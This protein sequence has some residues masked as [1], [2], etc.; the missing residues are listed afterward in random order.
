MKL[1]LPLGLLAAVIL[2]FGAVVP[3]AQAVNVTVRNFYTTDDWVLSEDPELAAKN[4]YNLYLGEGKELTGNRWAI[5]LYGK[6]Q[7]G[8]NMFTTGKD[9]GDPE[10][11]FSADIEK[12]EYFKAIFMTSYYRISSYN[13]SNQAWEKPTWGRLTNGYLRLNSTVAGMSLAKYDRRLE[14]WVTWLNV[15]TP[16]FPQNLFVDWLSI[17]YSNP[18]YSEF[19]DIAIDVVKTMNEVNVLTW[20]GN[21]NTVM[22]KSN[23]DMYRSFNVAGANDEYS[24]MLR[25][26]G[27]SPIFYAASPEAGISEGAYGKLRFIS[28]GTHYTAALTDAS[29]ENEEAY[30]RELEVGAGVDLRTDPSRGSDFY[31]GGIIVEKDAK[32]Y[33]LS[34]GYVAQGGDTPTLVLGTN[35]LGDTEVRFNIHESFSLGT[36]KNPWGLIRLNTPTN[37]LYIGID[38]GK[39]FTIYGEAPDAGNGRAVIDGGGT[40]ALR[41]SAFNLAQHTTLRGGTTLDFGDSLWENPI[42]IEGGSLVRAE[43]VTGHVLINADEEFASII[44]MGGLA[45]ELVQGIFTTNS[46]TSLRNIGI[47][48]L[49]FVGKD[50]NEYGE[51]EAA[52]TFHVG[53][54]H[55]TEG[56]TGGTYLLH[57][58]NPEESKISFRDGD[59]DA[60]I[61]ITLDD[62]VTEALSMEEDGYE[63]RRYLWFSNAA[64][65]AADV[66]FT[67]Y[68]SLQEWFNK[69]FVFDPGVDFTFEVVEG[70]EAG[71]GRFQMILS[72]SHIWYTSRHGEEINLVD[73]LNDPTHW[74]KVVVDSH[75]DVTLSPTS[76]SN[77]TLILRYLSSNGLD[78]SDGGE[79]VITRDDPEGT[80]YGLTIELNNARHTL[81]GEVNPDSTFKKNI[82]V[83]DNSGMTTLHKTGEGVL[84]IDGNVTS[85]GTVRVDEVGSLELNG[86]D[87]T[88]GRLAGINGTLR[89]GGKLTVTGVSDIR[90]AL[91]NDASVGRIV[92]DGTLIVKGSL[93]AGSRFST[94]NSILLQVD[95]GGIVHLD[96]DTGSYFGALAGEGTIDLNGE[97]VGTTIT[98]SGKS[99][100]FSG[101]LES[102]G[103][104]T[105]LVLHEDTTQVLRTA[106]V[107]SWNVEAKDGATLVLIGTGDVNKRS[108]SITFDAVNIGG[109]DTFDDTKPS[110]LCISAQ[111]HGTEYAAATTVRVNSATF[112]EDSIIEL[113]YNFAGADGEDLNN[114]GPMLEASGNIY[115]DRFVTFVLSNLG[116]SFDL[117]E[118]ADLKDLVVMRTTDGRIDG[119][120]NDGDELLWD[121]SGIFMIFYR[122]IDM[123][124]RGKD[125][126]LNA[127]VQHENVF[128]PYSTDYSAVIGG[129]LLWE[130]RFADSMSDMD[131]TLYKVIDYTAYEAIKGDSHAA[132]RVLAA[133]AGSTVPT[134]GTAQRDAIRSHMIRMRDHVGTMGLNSDFSYDELPFY[135]CWVEGTGSFTKF[136][137]DNL[138]SGYRLNSWGGS[139]GADVDVDNTTSVGIALSALY[140]D[141]S[142]G[143]ADRATGDMDSVYLSLLGRFRKNRWTHTLI[144][145]FGLSDFSVDRTVNYGVGQYETHGETSGWGLAL[146]YE[147]TR[148]YALTPEGDSILQ[149]LLNVSIA[150]TSLRAYNESGEDDMA[151]NVG[152]Q[153]WFSGSV[154]VGV[155]WLGEVGTA[156]FDRAAQLEL[157]A[158][159]AQDFGDT[160]GEAE[161][162]LRANPGVSRKMKANE[163][164]TTALQLGVGLRIPVNEQATIYTNANT[165]FRSGMS[166]WNVTA[167]FRYDF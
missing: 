149:P 44:N 72:A 74:R 101:N 31:L 68:H 89:I 57:F 59:V 22:G 133:V 127:R 75:L 21:G 32:N 153:E 51:T 91:E 138:M 36:A 87:S 103:Q 34:S 37:G 54:Q 155:R 11:E 109:T 160:C 161:V 159:V 25:A 90:S 123:R 92:G 5:Y 88:I 12:G 29:E 3:R 66:D 116:G 131:S 16:A 140:G 39:T 9:N 146:M 55:L 38:E 145:S 154:A 42:L 158:N 49:S 63:G 130:A 129:Q 61:T 14:E 147:I 150:K 4:V 52:S 132:S 121:T 104:G 105:I 45:A 71:N 7:G 86:D 18:K 122:D 167:G 142:A 112:G 107:D 64:I 10:G 17:G 8:L 35:H 102:Y 108:R 148:D 53:W 13:G 164:G 78:S 58:M 126:V 165:D 33:S 40:L 84:T 113:R 99:A 62:D 70:E 20:T 76:T 43:G 128:T 163:A 2:S 93:N 143:S 46:G 48:T 67:D 96:D 80:G 28:E 26:E 97:A 19:T 137:N 106:G 73:R 56:S 152:K 82:V 115:I 139:L 117:K 119:Y 120:F 85:S 151:L 125:I 77:S 6:V 50:V 124:V 23:E 95:A 162:A 135:H 100:E 114:V 47:G 83:N 27:T 166:T 60:K 144:A 81:W 1:H 24:V 118:G 94:E 15:A 110:Y 156:V 136:D 111:G 41:G 141:F 65:E 69:R 30:I 79:L 98:L 157:R 134:L